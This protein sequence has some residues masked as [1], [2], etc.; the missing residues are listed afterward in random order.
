MANEQPVVI[1]PEVQARAEE[2]TR[3]VAIDFHGSRSCDCNMLDGRTCLFCRVRN[4]LAEALAAERRQQRAETLREVQH[5]VSRLRLNDSV[6]DTFVGGIATAL[7]AITAAL[8][9]AVPGAQEVND[10]E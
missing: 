4:R 7:M 10:G 5:L 6:T 1:P 3:Q 9:A 2:L 8:D